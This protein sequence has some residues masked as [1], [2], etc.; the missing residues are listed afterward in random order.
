M[1]AH[2]NKRRVLVST[3]TPPAPSPNRWGVPNTTQVLAYLVRHRAWGLG[4]TLHLGVPEMFG[5]MLD[6]PE[7]LQDLTPLHT[8]IFVGIFAETFTI[9]LW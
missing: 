8:P 9:N 5:D 4:L 1:V 2:F 7:D 3:S 6:L